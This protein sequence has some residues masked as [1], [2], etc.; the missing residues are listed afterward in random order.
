[1]ASIILEKPHV[2]LEGVDLEFCCYYRF[3]EPVVGVYD[4]E[5]GYVPSPGLTNA[6]IMSGLITLVVDHANLQTANAQPFTAADVIT[7]ECA[8]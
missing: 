3:S 8:V 1:M 6:Q 2:E 4:G 7:W 5:V